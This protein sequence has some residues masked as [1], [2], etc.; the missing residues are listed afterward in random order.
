MDF[1][2]YLQALAPKGETLLIVRQ[3]PSMSGDRPALHAD[4]TPKYTWPAQ[5]PD[6]RR[7]ADTAWYANTGSFIVD[8]FID[9][10]PSASAV[11]CEYVLCMMLDDVGTKSK[12]PPLP[13]T[14]IMETSEGSFQWGY[15]FS[16]QPTKGESRKPLE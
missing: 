9:G 8:R 13:P 16:D 1:V 15:G 14:W 12:V 3:K 11:N 5:L 4:G 10:K 7:K 2:E 6:R